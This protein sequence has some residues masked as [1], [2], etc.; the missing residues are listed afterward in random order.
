VSDALQLG[1]QVTVLLQDGALRARMGAAGRAM[2]EEHRGAL[3]RL[4]RLLAPLF[5]PSAP[6]R[7]QRIH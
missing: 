7:P 5:P 2:L 1:D 3:A 4:Q 6:G